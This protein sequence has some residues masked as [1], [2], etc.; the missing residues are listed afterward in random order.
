VLTD[1]LDH[2]PVAAD[3]PPPFDRL[4]EFTWRK[5]RAYDWPAD[6]ARLVA[7]LKGAGVPVDAGG[8]RRWW[9]GALALGVAVAAGAALWWSASA[10]LDLTGRWQASLWHGESTVL[11]FKQQ[12]DAVS[13]LSEPIR[14]AE[15]ADWAEYRTFW[16]ERFKQP[17]DAIVYRGEGRLI[18]DPGTALRIDIGFKVYPSPPGE[19]EAIDSG[20]LSATLA[21]GGRRLDGRI[22]LNG[23]Q[24]EQAAS[25][26]R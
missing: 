1:R 11:H 3:L 23:S 2:P 16:Q 12:G 15:R 10:P 20:N 17:L 26:M 21:A 19:G 14:I 22:W 6:V 18:Q 4:G 25:L 8:G 9:L 24:A 7:D 13:Y 5:L